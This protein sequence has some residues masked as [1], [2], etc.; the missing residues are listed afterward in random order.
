MDISE[1]IPACLVDEKGRDLL[2]HANSFGKGL[3]KFALLTL[4]RYLES[5]IDFNEAYD[6][7][8][9]SYTNPGK[10]L[11]A[12]AKKLLLWLVVLAAIIYALWISGFAY[13]GDARTQ[14]K[15]GLMYDKGLGVT[16]D[17]AEAVRW[18]RK[19]ADQGHAGAQFN[20]GVMYSK[21]W[22]VTQDYTEAVRWYRK[23]AKQGTALA[24]AKLGLM[25]DNAWGVTQDYSRAHMWYSL[26]T[27]RGLNIAEKNRDLLA[28]KM[29]PAQIAKAQKLARE[30]KPK[31]K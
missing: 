12:I 1:I 18:Y 25:Y 13:H 21:G 27:A 28:K 6:L 5:A 22:G 31:G 26:A 19:A 24:Q 20:L 11:Q 30:W 29:T 10:Y 4:E 3:D 7:L 16:Q 17:Y 15:L 14:N 2:K 23:A 9:E 8:T